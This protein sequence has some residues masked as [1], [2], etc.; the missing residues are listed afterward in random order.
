MDLFCQ[1]WVIS[2]STE[3]RKGEIFVCLSP[4]ENELLSGG[5]MLEADAVSHTVNTVQQCSH[6]ENGHGDERVPWGGGSEYVPGYMILL[7]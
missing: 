4:V 3:K 5:Q 2:L 6:L 7:L 1:R